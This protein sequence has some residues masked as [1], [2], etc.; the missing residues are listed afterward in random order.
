MS[1]LAQRLRELERGLDPADP[2]RGGGV[3]IIGYG[4]V[5]AVLGLAD[6]PGRVLK[7]I[8]GFPSRDEA[9]AYARVVER[10]LSILRDQDV[11]VVPTE[12][13]QVEPVPGR[14]VVYL[15]QPRLD[16]GAL[17]NSLL[18]Q[19]ALEDLFPLL[20]RVL[21]LVRRVL[22]ANRE[23]RDGRELAIDAQLSNWHWPA[24]S[25]ERSLPTLIDVGT[26]FM[27]KEGALE[28]GLE[29]FLRPYPAPAR[30]WLRR[31]RAVERYIGAFF[32]FDT[33]VIDLLGNFF[34]EGAPER[35]P[36]AIAFVNDWIARQP[37]PGAALRIEEEA[38]RRYYANDASTLELA[39]RLRHLQ[40]F[41]TTRLLRRRYDFLL[42]GR[43]VRHG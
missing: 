30:W 16:P 36:G 8:S 4:E 21:A 6:L 11:P 41:V 37:G 43:I 7:R 18:R 19:G 22:D 35:I 14:H 2:T 3:E 9:N 31:T 42:P 10:Y 25:G 27:R 24:G 32:R 5:S 34:K 29:V 20:E 17:G 38:V 28:M 39:L 26:P 23:R 33:T 40:R 1:D 15:V 13:V 12:L